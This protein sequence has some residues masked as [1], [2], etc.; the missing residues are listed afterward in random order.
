WAGHNSVAFTLTS[1][2]GLTRTGRTTLSTGWTPCG[3][4]CR[5]PSYGEAGDLRVPGVS[6]VRPVRLAGP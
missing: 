1:Y 3:R 2:G 5:A 4:P 6:R